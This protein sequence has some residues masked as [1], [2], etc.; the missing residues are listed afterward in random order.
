[1]VSHLN[2]CSLCRQVVV[3]RGYSCD[4]LYYCISYVMSLLLGVFQLKLNFMRDGRI[5]TEWKQSWHTSFHIT[6]HF[7]RDY[8]SYP[9]QGNLLESKFKCAFSFEMLNRLN[10]IQINV[11]RDVSETVVR[12][13]GLMS[14]R[15]TMEKIG[16]CFGFKSIFEWIFFRPV[17]EK[18]QIGSD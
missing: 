2:G 9:N 15:K 16:F 14:L 10:S 4:R 3:F 8:L 12:A 17:V 11:A 1:M 5:K 6:V 13:T 7:Q 18:D